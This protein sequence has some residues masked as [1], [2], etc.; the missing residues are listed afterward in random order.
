[1]FSSTICPYSLLFP[2]ASPTTSSL[3]HRHHSHHNLPS[4]RTENSLS[5]SLP[6]NKNQYDPKL[7]LVMMAPSQCSSAYLWK[8]FKI[9]R[10]TPCTAAANTG[11]ATVPVA[12][13]YRALRPPIPPLSPTSGVAHLCHKCPCS[14]RL[15]G[16]CTAAPQTVHPCITC[17]V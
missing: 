7:L 16:Y 10:N 2:L 1:M 5:M 9:I 3:T 12:S 11:L 15:H 6:Q 8:R 13:C 14:Q 17:A 4:R